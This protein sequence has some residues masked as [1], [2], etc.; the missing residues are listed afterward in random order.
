MLQTLLLNINL[1]RF[2][3][4]VGKVWADSYSCLPKTCKHFHNTSYTSDIASC[5]HYAIICYH[6]LMHDSVSISP[7]T[8]HST[9]SLLR[10]AMFSFYFDRIKN[11]HLNM[12]KNELVSRM[13]HTFISQNYCMRPFKIVLLFDYFITTNY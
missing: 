13:M 5:R 2:K 1:F 8:F 4:L 3:P 11:R 7:R 9:I 12:L 6:I 10:C